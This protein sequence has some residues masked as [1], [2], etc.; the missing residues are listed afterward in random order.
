MKIG[1]KHS[2]LMHLI[3]LIAITTL[4]AENS[5]ELIWESQGEHPDSEYGSSMTSMDFNGDGIDDLVVGSRSYEPGETPSLLGKIYFYYGG[6]IFQQ[7]L[8]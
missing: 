1:R 6:G 8:I 5:M 3:L 4:F 2:F 7:P